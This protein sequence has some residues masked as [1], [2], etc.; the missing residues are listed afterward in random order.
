[1]VPYFDIDIGKHYGQTLYDWRNYLFLL[2][3]KL[4]LVTESCLVGITKK[5]TVKAKQFYR[6]ILW[7]GLRSQLPEKNVRQTLLTAQDSCISRFQQSKT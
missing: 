6:H 4:I 5:I 3:L 7:P 1:M 2:G